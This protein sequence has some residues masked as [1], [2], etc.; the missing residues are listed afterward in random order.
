MEFYR[1]RKKSVNLILICSGILLLL[2]FI[3]LYSIGLFNGEVIA[4]GVAISSIFGL[5]LAF[6]IIKML[7]S[8]RDTSPLVVLSEQGIIAKVT[9]VSKAAGLIL[10]AD[11]ID[12]NLTKVGADTL[13][14]LT[15]DKPDH[16]GPIIRKKLSA[17]ATSG[18][19]DGQGNLLIFLTASAL[20]LEAPELLN[21]IE[22]YRGELDSHQNF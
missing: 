6:I 3:F 2:I 18:A 11:I 13:I 17:L 21:I 5:I 1:N 8:L 7:I 10:W 14:A 19:D 4:K 15:V 9:P 20:D 16:Y 22:K 12:M